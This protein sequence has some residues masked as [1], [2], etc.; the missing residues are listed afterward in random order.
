MDVDYRQL[1]KLCAIVLRQEGQKLPNGWV[2]LTPRQV[3][4]LRTAFEIAGG[5]KAL[6]KDG[7]RLSFTR[8]ERVCDVLKSRYGVKN[9]LTDVELSLE[10]SEVFVTH[11]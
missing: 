2:Q 11:N 6:R 1:R 4:A 5:R 3:F 9:P 7:R 8:V 10:G